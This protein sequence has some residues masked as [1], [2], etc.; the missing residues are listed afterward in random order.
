MKDGGDDEDEE[1]DVT[2]KGFHRRD[3]N[4]FLKKYASKMYVEGVR[5]EQLLL[6]KVKLDLEE[7]VERQY[8]GQITSF[9]NKEKKDGEVADQK[10]DVRNIK[11]TAQQELQIARDIFTA[12]QMLVMW[13]QL[14]QGNYV[15][16]KKDKKSGSEAKKR[17]ESDESDCLDGEFTF[18]IEPVQKKAESGNIVEE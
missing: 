6:V 18:K 14:F 1:E 12:D 2:Y 10:Q 9:F 5:D 17:S 8:I 4:R 15:L 11:K 16:T 7:Y 3:L 13:G